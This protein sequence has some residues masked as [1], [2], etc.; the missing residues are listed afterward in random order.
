M[1]TRNL[2]RVRRLV[3]MAALVGV[4]SIPGAAVAQTLYTGTPVP[5]VDVVDPGGQVLGT[6]GFRAQVAPAS[7]SAT[8]VLGVQ[9]LRSGSLAFTGG[10]IGG[11]VGLGFGA[12]AVG[13]VLTRR[14]RR[15]I[16]D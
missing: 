3:M 15:T 14:S 8:E 5:R 2:G 4:T 9:G 11:L 7:S 1:Q 6:Q 13:L 10:D 16:S 12:V